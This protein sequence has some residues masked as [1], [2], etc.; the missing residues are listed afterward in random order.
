M[1]L[2]LR[3]IVHLREETCVSQDGGQRGA[4]DVSGLADSL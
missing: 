3:M 2:L 1:N 4:A